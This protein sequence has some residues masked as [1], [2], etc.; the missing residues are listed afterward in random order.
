MLVFRC[1]DCSILFLLFLYLSYSEK[2][3]TV[4]DLTN[5]AWEIESFFVSKVGD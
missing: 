3:A 5:T 4:I 2:L 1:G